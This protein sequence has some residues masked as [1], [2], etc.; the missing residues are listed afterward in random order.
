MVADT[1]EALAERIV[2]AYEN[3]ALNTALGQAGLAYIAETCSQGHV[4]SLLLAA[5]MGTE[6]RPKHSK[7]GS[8]LARNS[9]IPHG[10]VSNEKSS[11][12]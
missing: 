11:L 2:L 12:I 5:T 10:V 1:A 4:D 9:K 3:E 6:G 8:S 7:R